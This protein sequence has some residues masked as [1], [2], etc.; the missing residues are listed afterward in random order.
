M[1]G[2]HHARSL[3][4]YVQI[5]EWHAVKHRLHAAHHIMNRRADHWL[6]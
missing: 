4:Q 3:G 5:R 6:P 1:G 2:A